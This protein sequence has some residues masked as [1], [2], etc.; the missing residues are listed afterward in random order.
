[1]PV[2]VVKSAELAVEF[3]EATVEAL[4]AAGLLPSEPAPEQAQG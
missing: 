4:D 1:V 3:M 2:N